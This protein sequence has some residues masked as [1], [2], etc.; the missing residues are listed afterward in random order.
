MPESY[1]P[2]AAFIFE[3]VGDERIGDFGQSAGGAAGLEVDRAAPELGT[4]ANTL[5]LAQSRNLTNT[6]LI[7]PEEFLETAPG[8]GAE[9]NA[10]AR[11][12]MVFFT[13]P[14]DG[15][16]FSVGSIA[17]AG[18]LSHNGYRNN[19]SQITGN[20]LRRFLDPKPFA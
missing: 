8:L 10:I 18:S 12:D 16:V 4:P 3:G 7:V 11:A 14:D 5:V 15:A 19:V 13:M 20:V 6:Y 9:E 2:E 17:W 1:R